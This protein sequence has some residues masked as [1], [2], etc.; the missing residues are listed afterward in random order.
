MVVYKLVISFVLSFFCLALVGCG[1][2]G[3]SAPLVSGTT[4]DRTSFNISGTI[5]I[6][7]GSIADQDVMQRTV[8]LIP[9][10]NAASNAQSISNPS[11]TGGYA[12]PFSG[13]YTDARYSYDADPVDVFSVTLLENQVVSLTAFPADSGSATALKTTL[14]VRKSNGELVTPSI[15]NA[16]AKS[17]RVTEKGDYFIEVQ[18]DEGPVLYLLTVSQG[19]LGADHSLSM[20]YDFVPGEVIVKLKQSPST[21]ASA[22]SSFDEFQLNE[23]VKHQLEKIEGL[24]G[25]SGSAQYGMKMS[26]DLSV[27]QA[28][29][30]LLSS[31]IQDWP[32]KQQAK[33][34]TL[35]YIETLKARDDIEWA[36]PNYIR[37][38]LASSSSAPELNPLYRSQWHYSL[39]DVPT[40]WEH[41]KGTGVIV[42]VVDTGI[43][44]QHAD[45]KANILSSGYDFVSQVSI[46]GDGDGIDSN[47]EDEGGSFHGSH[48]AGT[49]AAV[50]NTT[51]GVGVAY[52]ADIMPLRA[53]GVDGSGNDAD[54]A[55][56]ILYAAKLANNSNTT[57]AKKADV[58]NLSLG[59]PGFSNALK[60]AV[61]AAYRE[62]LILVAA[63]GNENSSTAFYPAAFSN[64]VS[65]SAVGQTKD[66]APYSNFGSTID[67]AAPGGDMSQDA[68][69]DGN[70]DGVLSTI[71]ASAYAWFQGT[72]MAAPHVAGVAA[73][74]KSVPKS[75][76]TAASFLEML[77]K[78]DLTDDIGPS[79]KDN[80]YGH[81]LINASKA[82]EIAGADVP[83]FLSINPQSISFDGINT[84][85]SMTLKQGGSGATIS[86]DPVTDFDNNT[87]LDATWLNVTEQSV[88]SN[89]LGRYLVTV[90]RSGLEVGS[91]HS[92]TIRVNYT[93]DGVP[94]PVETVS[95]LMTVPD[96]SQIATVG[97]LFV[98]LI[99][100][101][102][103]EAAENEL[104]QG[105]ESVLIEIFAFKAAEAQS[106]YY[107]Y[108]FDDVPPGDYFVFASTNMDHDGLVSD[109]GEAQG[110]YPV[111]GNAS[112]ITVERDDISG[113]DFTVG[114]QNV[115]DGQSVENTQTKEIIRQIPA[116][117]LNQK[118]SS[119]GLNT[120]QKQH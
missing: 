57:P 82:V 76:V 74:M 10:N 33:W 2:G 107:T 4:T 1:G 108:S 81:G 56:A 99:E 46:A 98:G 86:V 112:I 89:K 12:S 41:S 53:L 26:I 22:L 66:R 40:A 5:Q 61:D 62:G 6:P 120:I 42:A 55:Q 118:E 104:D 114:Y 15:S 43:A 38:A 97:E 69:G 67:V 35:E 8:V 64:V 9:S 103:Q 28:S 29:K 45:L 14:T 119:N 85:T 116:A 73:L 34:K 109:V 47:P 63:A 25:L 7:I 21:K 70:V 101:S 31:N 92:G 48:V 23:K 49:V 94:Q 19:V 32:E 105:Q 87:L 95:V 111:V 3:D 13:T 96:P 37:K 59:G 93:K 90:D 106:G 110:D 84:T 36:E 11:I 91:T 30:R 16:E 102:K 80:E 54:I 83:A 65:V 77:E 117:F 24:T 58:I 68:N 50:N 75:N 78:G 60:S 113:L 71:N 44:S 27:P 39:I 88:D 115:V 18:A 51:G 100:R 20:A 79:G 52:E 72:S 17:I